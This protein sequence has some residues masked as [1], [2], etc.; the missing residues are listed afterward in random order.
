MSY[1]G[2]RYHELVTPQS[3]EL[4]RQHLAYLLFY[5][6]GLPG[7]E[8]STV[9][10]GTVKALREL[11]PPVKDISLS[12]GDAKVTF[13]GTFETGETIL[14]RGLDNCE[15]LTWGKGREALKA[16]GQA[17]ALKEGG[18]DARVEVD[19]ILTRLLSVRMARVYR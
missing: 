16:Q 7:N 15:R 8:T 9:Y 3:G 13:P 10:I 4:D 18:N 2:W 14:Y 12:I 6:N 11:S 19:G 5:F 1:T 17:L